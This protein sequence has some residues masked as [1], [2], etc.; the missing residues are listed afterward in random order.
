MDKSIVPVGRRK[1]KK[2]Q[3]R[4]QRDENGTRRQVSIHPFWS[5]YTL[6]QAFCSTSGAKIEPKGVFMLK[7]PFCYA[8]FFLVLVLNKP[9]SRW[10]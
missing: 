3:Q 6:G 8:F 2:E 5:K 9:M 4:K 10:R 1:K 7:R